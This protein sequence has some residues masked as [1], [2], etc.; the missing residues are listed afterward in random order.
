[1][2]RIKQGI[3]EAPRSLFPELL[4]DLVDELKS[5]RDAGQPLIYEQHFPK[6]NAVRATVVWDK[7]AP[8]SDEDRSATILQA[9]ERAEG[10]DF[11][12]GIALSIGLTVPEAYASGL[13]PYQVTPLLRQNDVVT[14]E[15]CTAAMLEQGASQLFGPNNPQ[16]RFATEEEAKA[17]VQR[18]AKSLP[19]SEPVWAVAKEVSR[20]D[21]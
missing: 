4:D 1:M 12:D 14:K 17:C 10:K 8:L 16:L 5:H 21:D 9:Y 7:W 13:L 19:A 11:R 6:T 15:Q 3:T 18:L 20:I 2:P